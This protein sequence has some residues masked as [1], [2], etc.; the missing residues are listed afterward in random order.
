NNWVLAGSRSETGYPLLA[1]DTH[2][3]F[4]QPAKFME[5]HLQGGRFNVRGVYLA[6]IPIAVMGNNAD[7]AWGMTVVTVDDMDFFVEQVNPENSGEYLYKGAW[8]PFDT[9]QEVIAVRGGESVTLTVRQTVHGVIINDL[10]PLLKG[11]ASP[12]AMR[13]TGQ[14]NVDIAGAMLAINLA[15]DWQ[16][17]SEGVRNFNA[18][19][20]NIIYADRQG[21]I[22]WRMAAQVPIRKDADRLL[23]RP[24]ASGEYDW[25]GTIPFEEMPFLY[26]PPEG[27]IATANHNTLADDYPYYI[28]RYWA[29]PYRINR[30]REL[31]EA[32]EKHSLESMAAIQNDNRSDYA[33]Q[34]MPTLLAA[35][36]FSDP[37]NALQVEAVEILRQWDFEMSADEIAPTLFSAWL[38]ALIEGIYGDEMETVG[39]GLQRGYLKSPGVLRQNLLR[40]MENGQSPWFDNTITPAMEDRDAVVRQALAVAMSDLTTRLGRDM[41]RWQWAKLHSVTYSHALSEDKK[42]GD[43]LKSWLNLDIGP[44]GV[45]GSPTTAN[46]QAYKLYNPFEVTNGPSYRALYDL[47]DLDHSKI[48]LPTGQSGNPMDRHYGD[49]TPLYNSGSYRSVAFTDE[50]VAAATVS[51]LVL[52]P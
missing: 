30:I 40:L 27:Y 49:Q 47:G 33:A 15:H 42:Y 17:F 5:M 12:V 11:S 24:G 29:G 43:F 50:A 22:G 25:Q 38:V 14:D 19:G 45:S 18:P 2:M 16:S 32:T 48:I 1:N 6:G 35:F 3:G 7:I 20:Q 41:S 31:L 10:H 23:L 21:N 44:F 9:R 8:L 4:V 26:N 36:E 37:A 13:W 39:S 52:R 34:L 51:T 28:S 46:A